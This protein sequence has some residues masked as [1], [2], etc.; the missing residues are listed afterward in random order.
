MAKPWGHIS[1]VALQNQTLYDAEHNSGDDLVLT[2]L[3]TMHSTTS[4]MQDSAA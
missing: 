4:P 3:T 2:R 1:R